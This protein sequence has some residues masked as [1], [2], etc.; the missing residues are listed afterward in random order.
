MSYQRIIILALA[1]SCIFFSCK[2][3]QGCTDI[4]SCNFSPLAEEDNGTCN[5][6]GDSCDDGNPNTNDEI[7]NNNCDCIP[8]HEFSEIE[9]S[10][11]NV[12]VEYFTAHQCG[13]CPDAA[14]IAEDLMAVHPGRVYPLAIHAGN[15]A[16]TN[17]DYPTDWTCAEGDVFWSQLDFQANPIGR[18]NR[19]EEP[20]DYFSPSQWADIVETE[21]NVETPLELQ[22]AT[23][24]IPE[25]NYLSIHVF[26]QYFNNGSP[27]NHKLS[28]LISE[29]NLIGDQLDYSVDPAHIENYE[30][31]NL[32]RGSLTGAEGISIMQ[33]PITGDTFQ[34][35][36]FYSWN[37]NWVIENC[38]II[39]IVSD[40]NG[41]IINC[42]EHNIIN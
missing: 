2:K 21:M 38:K 19:F 39:A 4:T 13:N 18:I 37:N 40:Q 30:F 31:N 20:G 41:Y 8:T 35:D 6:P 1:L 25:N 22:I 11:K 3:E 15:L 29:S 28:I 16:I 24:W 5:Y 34:S 36:L 42:L 14:D 26:G 17:E 10:G 23:Y 27:G 12:L 7:I 33:N 9:Q 32:L